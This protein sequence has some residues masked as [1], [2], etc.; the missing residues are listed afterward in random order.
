MAPNSRDEPHE[1]PLA[2]CTMEP[3]TTADKPTPTTARNKIGKKFAR[4]RAKFKLQAASNISAG[5]KISRIY[6]GETW[7]GGR[8]CIGLIT[9]PTSTSV[10]VYG[11]G[12]HL[13]AMATAE[14]ISSKAISMVM[15]KCASFIASST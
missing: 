2:K 10:I 6:S 5:R 8:K 14:A 3:V 15:V 9:I 4:R 13:V 12:S 7:T 1:R 11:T